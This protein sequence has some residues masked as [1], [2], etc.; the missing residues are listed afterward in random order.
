MVIWFLIMAV[1]V[2]L[3]KFPPVTH[4]ATIQIRSYNMTIF[5]HRSTSRTLGVPDIGVPTENLASGCRPIDHIVRVGV[6][7][8]ILGCFDVRPFHG[9]AGSDR[10]EFRGTIFR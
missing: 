3:S 9:I 7:E 5:R 6:G 4:D 10:S 2:A 1:R 8:H